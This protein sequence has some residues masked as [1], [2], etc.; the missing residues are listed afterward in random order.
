VARWSA[1]RIGPTIIAAPQRGGSWLECDNKAAQG[2]DKAERRVQASVKTR[3]CRVASN[4][5]EADSA[6]V[7]NSA[8]C[9]DRAKCPHAELEEPGSSLSPGNMFDRKATTIAAVARSTAT[10]SVA[11]RLGRNAGMPST[12]G[13]VAFAPS[14]R[15]APS[16][17]EGRRAG[18]TAKRARCHDCGHGNH[19]ASEPLSSRA[20][21]ADAVFTSIG[22]ATIAL[23]VN[24]SPA[25]HAPVKYLFH[26]VSLVVASILP[27][28]HC[29]T[30]GPGRDQADVRGILIPTT[31]W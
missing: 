11:V 7:T 27:P 12:S 10:T 16:R 28:L 13:I 19:S 24:I 3:E 15:R 5:E 8:K 2:D 6:E 31:T 22:R 25:L 21:V 29:G 14:D 26:S 23:A 30:T 17:Y 18:G 1:E 20:A 9:E 4:L